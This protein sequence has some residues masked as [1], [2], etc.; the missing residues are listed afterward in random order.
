M[1]ILIS[2]LFLSLSSC[3][4]YMENEVS[5]DFE[6]FQPDY[7]TFT[8]NKSKE[9]TVYEGDGGLFASDRRANKVGDIITITLDETVT[10]VNNA[11][12]TMN[13]TQNYTF[14]L[15]AALFGPS[16]LLAKL[17]FPG[18]VKEDNLSTANSAE[19]MTSTVTTGSNFTLDGTI[20][21]TVVRVY[22]NGNLEIKGARKIDYKSGT[23]FVRLSGVIRPEDISAANTV[24][25]LKI[26]DAHLSVTG[27]GD[28]TNVAKKGWLA[29]FF[30][31]AKPF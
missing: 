22:P 4:T 17:F 3:A 9:G 29:S 28:A 10:A 5:K 20:S 6:S 13:K 1:R 30:S 25:S 21:V 26:A 12:G 18:G 14:D 15:P 16:S 24:S 8:E 31:Y 7:S 19:N 11:N 2:F 27:T 23:E